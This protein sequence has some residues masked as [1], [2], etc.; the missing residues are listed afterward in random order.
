MDKTIILQYTKQLTKLRR[1]YKNGGA[2]HKP[3]LLLAICNL[4]ERKEITS[5]RICITPELIAE[6]KT[7]WSKVVITEHVPNFSLPFFHMKSEP[8]WTL[9]SKGYMEIPTTSS[10]SIRSLTALRES[11]EYAK[12]DLDLFSWM[13]GKKGNGLIKQLLLE[14]Y[15]PQLKKLEYDF[16]SN[17]L[18]IFGNQILNESPTDYRN[19]IDRLHKEL[20]KNEF[21]EELF[22]RGGAFK[23]EIPKLYSYQCAVSRM[24]VDA[25]TNAQ[26]VDACHI[27]PFSVSK[28]DTVKNGISLCPNVHR[29]FDRGLISISD[30]YRILVSDSIQEANSPY[31]F[32]QFEGLEIVL[33]E[34]KKY[35]PEL[36]N[37]RWHRAECFIL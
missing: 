6:F 29:A 27:V 24:R 9:I 30:K 5:N 12:I 13:A 26:L 4:I 2:P 10:G 17:Q 16:S 33:P 11:V 1:D 34:D 3:V 18:S 23:R 28:D 37:F 7:I 25:S 15:F 14:S 36:D 31:S 19:Q 21:E 20:T 32:K 8:F 22:V 35:Y